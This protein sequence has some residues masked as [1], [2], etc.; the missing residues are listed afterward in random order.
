[1][2]F[3]KNNSSISSD[4]DKEKRKL[5]Y[6]KLPELNRISFNEAYTNLCE[7]LNVDTSDLWPLCN[8]KNGISISMVR[9]ILVHGN[10]I[11][12]EAN[13]A[14]F[15]VYD[16]LRWTAERLILSILGWDYNNSHVSKGYLPHMTSYNEWQND[17]ALLTSKFE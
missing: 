9:N 5:I 6:E 8:S 16:H 13:A 14:L 11:D 12:H 7:S 3:I 4:D 15:S 1:M 2:K 10:A 17:R